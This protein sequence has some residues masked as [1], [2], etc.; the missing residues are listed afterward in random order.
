MK[1]QLSKVKNCDKPP[2]RDVRLVKDYNMLF[3]V[4]A[5][6]TPALLEECFKLRYQVYCVETGF[7]DKEQFVDHMERDIYDDR[8]VS[9]LLIHKKTGVVAGT[10]RLILPPNE[11]LLDTLPAFNVSNDLAALNEQ[12][13]P[14]NKTAE[15][16]RF[17][18]SKKFRKRHYDTHF[19]G[20]EENIG[21][22]TNPNRVI[23]HITLGLMKAI[24][25]MSVEH[26]I[27]HW[28]IV[29]EPALQRLLRKL[30]IY[31]IAVGGLV[32]YHGRRRTLYNEM[33]TVLDKMYE[34]HHEIWAVITN[35][36]QLWPY[37]DPCVN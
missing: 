37:R 36:G 6:D 23:P 17:S 25:R 16:S 3:D 4:I 31:F 5:A 34:T 33:S 26:G 11:N 10:V 18:I 8:S 29:I 2:N 24:V 20:I 30:G 7:E 19:P 13:L 32:E 1:N 14:R 27:T 28:S 21:S 35:Y 15:I 22:L 9:S 12:I